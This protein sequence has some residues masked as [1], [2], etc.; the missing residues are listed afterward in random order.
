M[1]DG[2]AVSIP[3][4]RRAD[5]KS[6]D[7]LISSIGNAIDLVFGVGAGSAL[8]EAD[9]NIRVASATTLSRA[10]YKLDLMHMILRRQ[11]WKNTF[12]ANIPVGITLCPLEICWHNCSI[13]YQLL[14]IFS[15]F[16]GSLPVV[17]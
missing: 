2:L 5:V 10:T 8:S 1:V 11:H 13:L 15:L 17:C 3:Q 14:N 7:N 16:D 6:A 12:E 9:N 4:F